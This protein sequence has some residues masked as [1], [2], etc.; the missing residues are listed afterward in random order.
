MPKNFY[1][2]PAKIYQFPLRDRPDGGGRAGET[3]ATESVI[4]QNL[5]PVR[6]GKMI[7]GGAW[8]H[9]EAIQEAKAPGK[10]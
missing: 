7:F 4:V 3:Q 9:E 5:R 10:N 2:E 6:F 8:Y 1:A